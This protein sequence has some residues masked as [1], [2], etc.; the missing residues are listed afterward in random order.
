MLIGKNKRKVGKR[1]LCLI[2]A[3]LLSINSFAAIVSDNDGSAFVT[4]AEFEA[5]KDNFASQVDQY[6]TSIDSKIDGAIAAYL[7]GGQL[8]K[9][10]MEKPILSGPIYTYDNT[11]DSTR[12]RYVY[13]PPVAVGTLK[14]AQWA[15][16]S[17]YG[18]TAMYTMVTTSNDH[19]KSTWWQ[20]KLLVSDIDDTKRIAAWN[21]RSIKAYDELDISYAYFN[22][23]DV[24]WGSPAANMQLTKSN[25]NTRVG[26]RINFY[27]Y[28]IASFYAVASI[29]A[30]P[31]TETNIYVNRINNYWGDI[32]NQNT[33]LLGNNIAYDCFSN[34]DAN[35]NWRYNGTHENLKQSVTSASTQTLSY[36]TNGLFSGTTS[37]MG[38]FANA[39]TTT[40]R[41]TTGSKS[42]FTSTVSNRAYQSTASSR[43]GVK[44]NTG[45]IWYY[46]GIGFETYYLSN[47]NQLYLPDLDNFARIMR[48]DNVKG[49]E[50]LMQDSNG[51]YHVPMTAGL[52][53]LVVKPE[54]KVELDFEVYN[55]SL[56]TL[57]TSTNYGVETRTTP[58]RTYIWAKTS[59]FT[60]NDPN[61]E[62]DL[63]ITSGG[64]VYKSTDSAYDKGVYITSNKATLKFDEIDEKCCIWLKW[65]TNNKLGG[66]VAIIPSRIIHIS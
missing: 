5:L 16:S 27:G 2:F 14:C 62:A 56:N 25:Y 49:Y 37:L 3:F 18:N 46:P 38:L 43:T 64:G 57:A 21:G 66:G 13:G 19:N 35:R 8:Q 61:S 44:W 23:S 20:T 7:A 41:V 50:I 58:S 34:M 36:V 32:R 60:S 11:G 59:P 47:W 42:N 28:A 31:A 48:D 45:E 29:N 17:P 65:S 12:M 24:N 9:K 55:Y 63:K 26:Q 10:A 15:D 54:E 52:P 1:A 33:I 51:G 4:K 40:N 22:L 39:H 30:E 6:N 53:L